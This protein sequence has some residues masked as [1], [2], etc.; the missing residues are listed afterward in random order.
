MAHVLTEIGHVS[1]I[2]VV[3]FASDLL[4]ITKSIRQ[5]NPIS[6]METMTKHTEATKGLG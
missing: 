3:A 5:D 4:C 1:L 6:N 2:V